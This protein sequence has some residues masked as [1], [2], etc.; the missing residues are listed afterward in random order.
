MSNT[1]AKEVFGSSL[2]CLHTLSRKGRPPYP[3]LAK[4]RITLRLVQVSQR[5]VTG[6]GGHE[7]GHQAGFGAE[8]RLN[9]PLLREVQR[10]VEADSGYLH[11]D[12]RLT[13][14]LDHATRVAAPKTAAA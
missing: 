4:R 9:L 10:Q 8:P 13:D 6:E 2:V 1:S 11:N 7:V 14:K 12:V 3:I 5:K